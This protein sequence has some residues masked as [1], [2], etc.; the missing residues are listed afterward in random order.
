MA[1]KDIPQE[2]AARV[3]ELREQINYHNYRYYV[4]DDPVISDA[5]F[6]RLLQ[7]LIGLEERYPRLLTP[8]S[9]SQRVGAAP[10]EKFETV[11]HRLP[12]ISLE[13]AF[14]EAKVR[15]FEERLQRFLRSRET[16]QYVLEPKMDG[17]AIELVYEQGRFRVGST[18][19]DGVRG[20]NVT[21]NLKTIHTIPLQILTREKPAP[22][23]L[24]VRGEVYMDLSEFKKLNEQRL[25]QGEPAFA[26]P[27]NAAAGSLRQLDPSITAARPLKIFCYGVGEVRGH[28]FASHWEVLQTLKTWGFRVS[29]LI[30]GGEGI[31]SAIAYHRR[32]EQQRHGL[33]YEID[34]MVIKVDSLSL[35][36]RLG[37]TTRSPRWA[38]A[39]KFAATQ[40]TTRVLDIVVNV[41]RTGAV[42]PM[43][44][45]QPV[46][47]GGV[48]VSR[49]TLH[50]EDEVAR[51]DV[52]VGDW[53]LVQRAGDVIPEVVKVI[54]ERRTGQEKP[55]QMPKLCPACGTTL[56]R[57]PGEKVTRCPNRDCFGAQT[58]AIMHFASKGAMDIDGLGEKIIRQ[59]V[60]A[61]LV[62][63]VSDLYRLT[64]GDLLPLERFAEKSAQ[65]IIKAIQRSKRVPLHRLIN[66]LGIRYVG[67][68]T[69]RILASHFQS[70]GGLINA[71]RDELLQVE[72]VGEQ[73]AAGIR[74][75]FDLPRHLELLRQ[76]KEAGVEELPPEAPETGPLAGKTFVF[77]GGLAH[78]SREEAKAQVTARGGKVSSSV[79]AK[80]DYVVV[81][82]DPGSKR[83]KA[84]E[85]G[86]PLLDESAFAELIGRRS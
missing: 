62:R 28:S 34:G 19:G 17:C 15:E 85:L 38:L 53:V 61:G 80:T 46:A 79:S 36:E 37:A 86:V 47:L 9:P 74:E 63:E 83:P 41:G 3:Q 64:E 58:R 13:D 30:E 56:V 25:S 82:A 60:S 54:S 24:E 33:P 70:L 44:V 57:P 69:A 49:A 65:N 66:A 21:Q 5:E 31:G 7:E 1:Q 76:L 12:M 2:V 84:V 40:E 55:F 39:Y 11:R 8:D 29:P 22:E 27:R 77:T 73:V 42:T 35:Q 16:L 18:R 43:A 72:G 52:R 59:L 81:G 71:S 45:M 4:L 68:A 50:N 32:L 6:D 26:N 78:I 48:T 51:K 14:S 20:E 10:L 23:L 75:Y 67:E